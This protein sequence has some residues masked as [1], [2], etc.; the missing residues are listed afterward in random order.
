MGHDEGVIVKFEEF[1][2]GRSH[3]RVVMGADE[4]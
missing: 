3:L 4:K 1:L 2:M